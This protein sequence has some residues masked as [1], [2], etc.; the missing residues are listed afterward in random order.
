MSRYRLIAGV[1]ITFLLGVLLGIF[2][3]GWLSKD[4]SGEAYDGPGVTSR[5]GSSSAINPCA[6]ASIF[7]QKVFNRYGSGDWYGFI[8]S[9]ID[10]WVNFKGVTPQNCHFY[11]REA[12]R[13]LDIYKPNSSEDTAMVYY[14][15]ITM[16]KKSTETSYENDKDCGKTNSPDPDKSYIYYRVQL[17]NNGDFLSSPNTGEVSKETFDKSA[18]SRICGGVIARA[19]KELG[20]RCPCST[21]TSSST[22]GS[23]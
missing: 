22:A 10:D 20:S 15:K 4:V 12:T 14:L 1:L 11:T 7:T 23:D 2:L 13:V 16:T 19:Y 18:G 3:Y 17:D 6:S 9:S 8:P 5:S 21:S